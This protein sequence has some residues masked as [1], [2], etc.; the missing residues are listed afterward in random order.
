MKMASA[1]VLETSVTNNS[2]SQ[3]SYHPDDLFQSSFISVE[4]TFKI[5]DCLIKVSP[6]KFYSFFDLK[7]IK[8]RFLYF[9]GT[10]LA[11]VIL[12]PYKSRQRDFIG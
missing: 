1:Q 11:A 5:S 4:F 12:L 6:C 2:P 10:E 9:I 8:F 3:D 7:S